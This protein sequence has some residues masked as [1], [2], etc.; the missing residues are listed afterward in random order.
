[1]ASSALGRGSGNAGPTRRRASRGHCRHSSGGVEDV[2]GRPYACLGP[3]PASASF[4]SCT[5][6]AVR[7]TLAALAVSLLALG[8]AAGQPAEL[9]PALFPEKSDW[10]MGNYLS[11]KPDLGVVLVDGE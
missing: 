10:Q 1:M 5:M 3:H 7:R 9:A 11:A 8:T 6:S 4:G 2:P